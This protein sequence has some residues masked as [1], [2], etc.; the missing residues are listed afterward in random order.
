ME[1]RYRVELSAILDDLGE[2]IVLDEDVEMET[3]VVGSETF[4]P[5]AP[6]HVAVSLTNTGAGI[7]AQGTVEVDLQATCARCLV[8]FTLHGVGVVEGFYVMP[9]HADE[10]PDEQDFELIADRSID[11]MP[12]LEAA[13]TVDLPFAPVHDESCAGICPTCGV[14]RNESTCGCAEDVEQSPFADLKSLFT[15]E[16]NA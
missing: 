10:L 5:V 12:A 13:L 1:Q 15:P 11:L 6:A 3:I 8:E 14:N 16:E 7:V 4:V 9:S 2:Q